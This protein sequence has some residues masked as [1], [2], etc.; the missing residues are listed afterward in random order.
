MAKPSCRA[1]AFTL[2]NTF[3]KS[4]KGLGLV[5]LPHFLH[6]FWSKIFP[7]LH[8]INGPNFIVWLP[9]ISE[10]LSNTCILIVWQPGCDVM[11]FKINLIFLIK[12]FF[13]HDLKVKTKI[14]ISWERKTLF[15]W[16]K[17][18]FSSSLKQIMK[19]FLEGE[20]PTLSFVLDS[21][22]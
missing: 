4:K 8:S 15:R 21:Y 13:L 2:Y 10:I 22:L 11:N 1:L 19:F 7:L 18:Y 9:L 16:N 20:S 6:N 5:S 17:E 12:L 14:Q 3:L